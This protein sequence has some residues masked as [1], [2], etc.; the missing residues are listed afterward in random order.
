[1]SNNERVRAEDGVSV[2]MP[3]RNEERHLRDSVTRI[4]SQD[5]D[6]PIEVVIALAPCTDRTH[7]I[8]HE[9]AADDERVRFVA[10]PSGRT[11]A[12][13]NAA[14]AASRYPVV[15]R[16][17]GHAIIPSD[18]VATA[19]VALDE[20]GADNVGGVMA[21]E[22]TSAFEQAVAR[23]MT[24]KL[25]VGAAS[26]HVGGEPGPVLTVYLGAFRRSAI[27]RVGGYDE[28]FQRAQDWEMNHRLRET[29]GLVYFIPDMQVTYRPRHSLLALAKQYFNYGRWRRVMA[30]R[31]PETVSLRYL[32]APA[33]TVGVVA[34]SAL[35][36]V[37]YAGGPKW[38]RAG[39]L[40]PLGY[41][42]L[43]V[44][45][46]LA[47]GAGLPP[48]AKAVLPV[49]YATMHHSWGLGFLL[50]PPSLGRA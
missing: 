36:V 39:M 41:T 31:Y 24:T 6:G 32:A 5:F 12:G 46:S 1:M 20:T 38:L 28:T 33:A 37:G 16:V 35:G 44:A 49:V 42:G 9:L 13:L 47:N 17:D 11:P 22:G 34:G 23:A 21:A 3:V 10:N 45:G 19:V 14:I 7:E 43:I 29:G 30:R 18:Y 2:V 40:G 48:K 8:A 25:G 26:F 50:S 27:D 15:V 4:L